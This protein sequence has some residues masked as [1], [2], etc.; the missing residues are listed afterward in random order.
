MCGIVG[1]VKKQIGGIY[2]A[3][4]DLFEQLLLC[5]SVRGADSTG[6]FMITRNKQARLLKHDTHP[7]NLFATPAWEH[8]NNYAVRE[9]RALIG[10]NRKATQGV[11]NND[12]AH[13]FHEGNIVLVHNGTIM[14]H[15][16]LKNTDVDSHAICHSF[17]EVGYKETLKKIIGAWALVWYDLDK[18]TLH[19]TRN[20][21]RPLSMIETADDIIFGSELDL[22]IWIA[23]RNGKTVNKDNV[24]VLAPFDLVTI[25][26][27]KFSVQH[28]NIKEDVE[29]FRAPIT[30]TGTDGDCNDQCGPEPKSSFVK[31]DQITPVSSKTELHPLFKEYPKDTNIVFA[32]LSVV[33][34][35]EDGNSGKRFR[36][37]GHA[38]LPGKSIVKARAMLPKEFVTT[39]ADAEDYIEQNKMIGQVMYIVEG[40]DKVTWLH[41]KN[42]KPDLM[43]VTWQGIEI[44]KLEF[45]YICKTYRCN[46]CAGA[47]DPN[48]ARTTSVT[49]KAPNVLGKITCHHCVNKARDKM[50]PK[51]QEELDDIN[52]V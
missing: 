2:A 14:N 12:N 20:A 10:H 34:A 17:Q 27:D 6:S 9:G 5:D 19:L 15:K 25:S 30:N 37:L 8:Y 11:I 13:P 46:K 42:L 24:K 4:T 31:E 35:F 39:M 3:D 33:E 38:W 47:I 52:A 51:V 40:T 41:L 29:P 26:F 36:A 16:G 7:M 18:H 45:E 32:P 22:L 23:R 43:E 28:E 48:Q 44:P 1:L 50:T 21:E 49:Y